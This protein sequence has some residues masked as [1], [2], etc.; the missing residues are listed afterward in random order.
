MKYEHTG[1][2]VELDFQLTDVPAAPLPF[3]KGASLRPTHA[4][5]TV[6]VAGWR[7]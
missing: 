4:V 7:A 1:T 5:V 3:T 2:T 6:V